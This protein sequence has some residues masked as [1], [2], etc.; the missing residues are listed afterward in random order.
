LLAACTDDPAPSSTSPD[1][2]SAPDLSGVAF[3]LT[4]DLRTGHVQVT[5]PPAA[6]T[7]RSGSGAPSF[8]LV[9]SDGVHVRIDRERCV[10]IPKNPTQQ[11]CS[12]DLEL[13]HR[14]GDVDLVTPVE[15]PRPPGA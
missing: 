15:F 8:S 11:R 14:L 1:G 5:Q 10:P 2:P 3:H 13:E 6:A 7:S 4:V 9:G 12:L